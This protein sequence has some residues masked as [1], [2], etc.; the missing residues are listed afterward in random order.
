MKAIKLF[1]TLF[2]LVNTLFAQEYSTENI[3]IKQG[4]QIFNIYDSSQTIELKP[5]KFSI[6]FLNKPYQEKKELFY[7]AQ[8]VVS[9]SKI[10]DEIEGLEIENIPY[11]QS[12]TGF[13]ADK[14][15]LNYPF[16]SNEG[17]QY[18]YY[19]SPK[20]KRIQKVGKSGEWDIYEWNV[21]GVYEND[22]E[23]NWSNYNK[24][25]VNLLILIDSN[26][27]GNIQHGELHNVQIKFKK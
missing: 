13:A 17:H 1:L 25:E 26:L 12:G 14:T 8:V 23:I 3:V 22:A 21:V 4:N 20:D 19:N 10:T 24:N 9:D 5:E 11:F 16:L 15:E 18:L 7:A 2:L 6:Q 27:S